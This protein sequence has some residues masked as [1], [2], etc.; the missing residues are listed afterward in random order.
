MGVHLS[1]G[2]IE[3]AMESIKLAMESIKL[4]MESI[5]LPMGSINYK[6]L[7]PCFFAQHRVYS[8]SMERS[9]IAKLST[10]IVHSEMSER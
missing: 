4:A 9:P 3:L 1:K 2:S 8:E 10:P 7:S 6:R 5:K